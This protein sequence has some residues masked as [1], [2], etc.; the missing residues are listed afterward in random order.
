LKLFTVIEALINLLKIMKF[1]KGDSGGP[2]RRLSDGRLV[3]LVSFGPG[4]ECAYRDFPGVYT[5]VAAIRPWILSIAK[6]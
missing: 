3:G 4:N 6:I 2:L 1:A 5:R